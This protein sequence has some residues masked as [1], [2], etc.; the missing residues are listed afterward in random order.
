M[1]HAKSLIAASLLLSSLGHSSMSLADQPLG[2]ADNGF[3]F[4]LFKQ[5]SKEQPNTNVSISPYSTATLLQMVGNGAAGKTLTEMKQLLGTT[6]LPASG[7]N[8][9]NKAIAQSLMSTNTHV[10]LKTANAIWYRT[11]SSVKPAFIATNQ[12]FYAATLDALNFADP[13]AVDH[14]NAWAS[15]KTEGKIPRIADG[16]IDP[17][18]TQLFLANAIYFKGKWSSPFEVR[19]TKNRSF[20]LH[21]GGEKTIAMMQQLKDW[22]YRQGEDYRAVRLPYEDGNL[23]MYILLPDEH[24]TPAAVLSTLSGDNWQ[25]V[26]K[27]GFIYAHVNLVIPKFKVEYSVELRDPLESLG[28]KSAFGDSNADFSGIAPGIFI[29]QVRHKTYVEINEEGT[30]AAAVTGAT[31]T[32]TAVRPIVDMTVDRPFLF[33][34]EDKSTETILFLG[35]VFDPT[36]DNW[37]ERS[38]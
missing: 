25:P 37:L 1:K 8:A 35:V 29:S 33:L 14:I 11:G 23:A 21:G 38:H 32:L 12:Q 7:V 30:E 15:A 36:S 19:N 26:S 22:E 28:M 31:A 3:G 4:R 17:Y 9:A 16:M 27:S 5:L 34:I 18:N 10:I 2:A 13:Q 20:H 6:G 24:S